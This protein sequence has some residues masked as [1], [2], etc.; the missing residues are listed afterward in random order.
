MGGG[1]GLAAHI[2]ALLDFV[3]DADDEFLQP[4]VVATVQRKPRKQVDGVGRCC[5]P[6]A[7]ERIGRVGRD[8]RVE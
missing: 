8:E 2:D 5:P 1:K 3:D 7:G 6:G 4:V